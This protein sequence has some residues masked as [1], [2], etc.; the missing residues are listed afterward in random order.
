[1]QKSH[2]LNQRIVAID[3]LRG[4]SILGILIMNI[5]GFAL[6]AI[7]YLNPLAQG[8][9]SEIDQQTYFWSHLLADQ[10]FMTIFSILFGA[11]LLLIGNKL[12]AKGYKQ[13]TYL[14]KRNT[15]LLFIGA[16]HAYIL[17]HG[18]ILVAYALCSFFTIW[19]HKLSPLKLLII[20]LIMLTVPSLIMAI[21]AE[22]IQYWDT[23]DI[24]AF[25][26]E[27]W[28]SAASIK[29]QITSFQGDWIEQISLRAEYAFSTH[30]SDF[31]VF[32]FWRVS[33]LIL[34]GMALFKLG[35]LTAK[36]N[37]KTYTLIAVIGLLLGIPLVIT[38]YELNIANAFNWH[39][40]FFN[41][42]NYN[43]WGSIMMAMAYISII[44][45]ICKL[46][47]SNIILTPFTALGRTALSNYL[48][49]T[50]ICTTIFYGHGLGY[51]GQFSRAELLYFVVI[52]WAFQLIVSPLW[53]KYFKQGPIEWA[54]RS[55]TLAWY[56]SSKT[57]DAF[58]KEAINS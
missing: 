18:D 4:V 24:L 20:S 43:Y 10:K 45:I 35:V 31:L 49:Q 23:K 36:L 41:G 58:P 48:G 14:L 47:G 40:S 21:G 25:S 51:F 9:L 6:I 16:I 12:A 46:L 29:Q 57:N 56:S 13:I 32:F 3:V 1:M 50:L 38:G 53:L 5:Q 15:I 19:F 39:Y 7:S 8:P 11:S 17:W 55:L 27:W 44:M 34:L 42:T 54:W 37:K 30:S 2:D 33:G 52:I 28:P 26:Q 22:T